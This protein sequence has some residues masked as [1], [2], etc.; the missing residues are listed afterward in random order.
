MSGKEGR[1]ASP[2]TDLW[3]TLEVQDNA[4]EGARVA[5]VRLHAESRWFCGHF[6][7][8]PILP[9]IALLA[10]VADLAVGR[11][12]GTGRPQHLAGFRRVRFRLPVRPGDRLAV[13]A[14]PPRG[15]ET[16]WPFQ[17]LGEGGIVCAG[18]LLL[19]EDGE[20]RRAEG[21]KA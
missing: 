4:L 9:G 12:S 18:T 7:G 6:P 3:H 20:K 14:I 19:A 17:V 15:T 11:F 8:K 1:T 13:T 21:D 5:T 16:G 2:P 10:M